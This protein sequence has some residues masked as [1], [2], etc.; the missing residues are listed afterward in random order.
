M[1]APEHYQLIAGY[2]TYKQTETFE[3]QDECG[4]Y[5]LKVIHR[6]WVSQPHDIYAPSWREVNGEMIKPVI[7]MDRGEGYDW[8]DKNVRKTNEYGPVQYSMMGPIGSGWTYNAIS[9]KG[10]SIAVEMY[11]YNFWVNNCNT[12][13]NN[14]YPALQRDYSASSSS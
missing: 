13:A 8:V 5:I 4:P 1:P 12:F 11:H 10:K 2:I 6:D 7:Y 14:L 3:K 9:L